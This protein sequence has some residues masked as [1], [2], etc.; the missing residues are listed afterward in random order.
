MSQTPIE[1]A[2]TVE[3]YSDAWATVAWLLRKGQTWSGKERNVAYLGKGDG[4]FQ[5]CGSVMGLDDPAD[6][7]T[8]V[9]VDWD[10]DGDLDLFIRA[11][12]TPRLVYME[13]RL[14]LRGTSVQF[15]LVAQNPKQTTVGAR[16]T[17]RS[18]EPEG[19][20]WIRTRRIGEGY[21]AQSSSWLH[22]GVGE[23]KRLRVEVRWP[24]GKVQDFGEVTSGTSHV[25]VQG[26]SS[27]REW[28]RA[29]SAEITQG[30]T[31]RPEASAAGQTETRGRAG[32]VVLAAP[33]PL[34]RLAVTTPKGAQAILGGVA[35]SLHGQERRDLVILLWS[36]TCKPCLSELA[37]WSEARDALQA[38][39]LSVL[40]LELRED[41]DDL[42]PS[43]WLE[44]IQWPYAK[45]FC[46]QASAR[47]LAALTSQIMGST[48][49]LAVPLALLVD[50]WG[51]VQ[52]LYRGPVEPDQVIRDRGMFALSGP[53]RLRASFPFDGLYLDPYKEPDWINLARAFRSNGL[54]EVAKE[55]ELGLIRTE[56]LDSAE[57]QF[58]FGQA[59]LR[60]RNFE[61]ALQH[62][63]TAVEAAPDLVRYLEPL[64]VC[65]Y[66]L[67]QWERA[68]RVFERVLELDGRNASTMYNL[69]FLLLQQ[70]ELQAARRYVQRL[71]PLNQGLA[72]RL[73][74]EIERKQDAKSEGGDAP[75]SAGPEGSGGQ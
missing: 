49:P 48:R 62:F 45:G 42:S 11:R 61:A 69:G 3:E 56:S 32:R 18:V 31:V 7:R 12:N 66:Q 75:P 27:A 19:Q 8:V 43:E 72:D 4:T 67:R 70:G 65:H 28:V 68:Q 17:V 47:I 21:L 26:E 57:S 10:G 46:S 22:V 40:A 25:L 39:G 9:R 38:S 52:V 51:R 33:L 2:D 60:Q 5:E 34:P 37:Q 35:E 74:S 30:T 36:Q 63:Q 54:T 13:N 71:R 55:Y 50:T 6:G 59:R 58:E 23:A 64:G 73:R 15:K 53:A 20:S 29:S 41:E 24:N 16:L 1:D 14:P 44:S